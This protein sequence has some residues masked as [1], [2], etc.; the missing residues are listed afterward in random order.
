MGGGDIVGVAG[1][2]VGLNTCAGAG[3]GIDPSS[4]CPEDIAGFDGSPKDGGSFES[5][6]LFVFSVGSM[7]LKT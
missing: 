2:S 1:D 4:V 7:Q 3:S 6:R 5:G